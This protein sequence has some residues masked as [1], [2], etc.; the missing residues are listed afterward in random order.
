MDWKIKHIK[1]IK[2]T[3]FGI[4]IFIFTLL[5]VFMDKADFVDISPVWLVVIHLLLSKDPEKDS[6]SPTF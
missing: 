4:I 2:T 3:V 6:S 5:L 1:E